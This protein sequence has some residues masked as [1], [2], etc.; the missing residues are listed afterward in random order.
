MRIKKRSSLDFFL[1]AMI[2]SKQ[3]HTGTKEPPM[4]AQIIAKMIIAK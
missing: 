3:I 2:A 4:A 1:K